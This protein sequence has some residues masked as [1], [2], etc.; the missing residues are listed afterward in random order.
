MYS[1]QI[2]AA[3]LCASL[4]LRIRSLCQQFSLP[5]NEGCSRMC[6]LFHSGGMFS[7]PRYT[8]PVVHLTVSLRTYAIATFFDS[9]GSS[10]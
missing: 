5:L 3:F 2:D 7:L 1:Q 9:R 6:S 8:L 4:E 10:S